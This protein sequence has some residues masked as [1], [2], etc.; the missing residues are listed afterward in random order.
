M[1]PQ[2]S[3]PSAPLDERR[4]R[5][6]EKLERELG[7]TVLGLLRDPTVTDIMLN[8]DGRLWVDRL[9][10]PMELV[11]T[12]TAS[13]AEALMGTVASTLGSELTRESPILECELPIDGSRFEALIPPVAPAP[14]FAIRL[15]AVAI[16]TLADYVGAGVMTERQCALIKGA[17]A[18]RQNILVVGGTGTG[19]TTLSNAII[20]EISEAAPDHR[21]VIIEDTAEIQC[22]AQNAVMLRAVDGTDMT[23]LLKATLRLRPDRIC[24]GEVRD[25]AALALLKSWNTGH[26]GGVSTIHANSGGR[27]G[28]VRL[29][30]LIGEVSVLPM[31]RL[32]GEAVNWV[33]GIEKTPQGLRRVRE[34]LSIA[35]TEAGGYQFL[36]EERNDE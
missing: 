31:G 11:G 17:V 28:L 8:P 30:Q 26:P 13:N 6:V 12:M 22:S 24:V 10:K 21:L 3:S 35:P 1:R 34:V 27:A 19:K 20:H 2:P 4:R 9:G 29:E 25:G 5:V 15:K 14:V 32:I 33:V 16:F 36:N 7:Q 23:R 18:R